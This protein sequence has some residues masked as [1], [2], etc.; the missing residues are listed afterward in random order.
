MTTE[1]K[2]YTDEMVKTI[3][4]EYNASPTMETV[5]AL[6]TTTGK[7]TRSLIAKLSREGVYKKQER[8]TK[9]GAVVQ[10]KA[11]IVRLI[12]EKTSLEA[13]SIATLVKATKTDLQLLLGAL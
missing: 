7:T 10:S 11:D 9:S 13:D 8:T 3:V 2:N 12:S 1:N 6:A 5:N 4:A